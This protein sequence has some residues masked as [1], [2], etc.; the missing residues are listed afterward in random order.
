MFNLKSAQQL[1][2]LKTLNSAT[3]FNHI[4][5]NQGGRLKTASRVDKKNGKLSDI[6]CNLCGYHTDLAEHC[7][8]NRSDIESDQKLST[9]GHPT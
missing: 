5:T 4:N 8:F 9:N 2:C 3:A 6:V 7:I 1:E